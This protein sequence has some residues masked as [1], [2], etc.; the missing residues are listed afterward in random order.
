MKKFIVL[1]LAL[2]MVLSLAA[3][4][5]N[6]NPTAAPTTAA[7]E[8][9]KAQD[10]TTAAPETTQGQDQTTAAPSGDAAWETKGL[11]ALTKGCLSGNLLITSVGQSSEADTVANLL[12][13]AKFDNYT[14]LNTVTADAIS[15]SYQVLVMVVGGSSKGLGGAGL[16]QDK[17]TARVTAVIEKAKELNMQ[18]VCMHIGG[19]D[20]RGTMSDAFINLAFPAADFAIVLKEGD[21][22]D[23]MKSILA[24]KNVPTAYIDKQLESRDVLAFMF[25]K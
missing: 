24:Q 5:G 22:D 21:T 25:G 20:R 4:G 6:S 9:T 13:R 12:K 19:T 1:V 3:C 14:Q 18:I 10:Q 16:D 8:T 2:A 7:P 15:N 23:L 11:P 17:E